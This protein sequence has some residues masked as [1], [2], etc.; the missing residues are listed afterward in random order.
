MIAFDA[1]LSWLGNAKPSVRIFWLGN[2]NIICA[3]LR[4]RKCVEACSQG[5]RRSYYA[6]NAHKLVRTIYVATRIFL[7]GRRLCSPERAVVD[8]SEPATE[9]WRP[10]GGTTQRRAAP[11]GVRP[12]ALVLSPAAVPMGPPSTLSLQGPSSVPTL[13]RLCTLGQP[14]NI[15]GNASEGALAHAPG[16]TRARPGNP[17]R[18]ANAPRSGEVSPAPSAPRLGD[19]GT[20]WG[21]GFDVPPHPLPAAP[22]IDRPA[23]PARVA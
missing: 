8:P 7:G 3:F 17:P 21:E 19:F 9:L 10:P 4:A 13:N 23:V 12:D 16:G 15:D 2:A 1:R 5:V 20:R 18:L 11:P 14:G 22:S 6:S